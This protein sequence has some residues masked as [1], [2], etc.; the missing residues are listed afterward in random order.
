[1]AGKAQL[2]DFCRARGIPHRRTGKL[3]VAQAAGQRAAHGRLGAR[4]RQP[5]DDGIPGR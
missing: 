5:D 2:Y 4:V 1:V 3:L